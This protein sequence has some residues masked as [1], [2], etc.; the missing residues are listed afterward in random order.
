LTVPPT[1]LVIDADE[2]RLTQVV[3]NL[4][5]NAAK[6]TDARGR[7][8][9]VAQAEGEEVV[10]TV[11]D[12]GIGMPAHLVPDVF[13]L[14]VQGPRAFD[15]SHGGL[16]LG[17]AIVRSLVT[18]HGGSVAAASE[19]PGR[20]SRFTVRLPLSKAG[21]PGTAGSESILARPDRSPARGTRVLVVDDNP[22]AADALAE[23]LRIGGYDVRTANDGVQALAVAASFRP[24]VALLDL[25]LPV[26]DG[27]SWRERLRQAP[28]TRGTSLVAL[29]ATGMPPTGS[30]RARPASTSIWSSP[31]TSPPCTRSS[32]GWMPRSRAA[33]RPSGLSD[34]RP[35]RR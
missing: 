15:R 25:G 14:F 19:G 21:R 28:E 26:M 30:G 11:R 4:L 7:I 12:N 23:A 16:G 27:T 29:T 6:Y 8:E 17:L 1:G 32:G 22:D 33:P 2:H 13:D 24:D 10:L 3:A 35:F 34:Q 20:G 31:W 9:V 18:L 5:T